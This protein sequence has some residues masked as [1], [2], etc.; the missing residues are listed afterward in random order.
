M[1]GDSQ[2]QK[3]GDVALTDSSWQ[4]GQAGRDLINAQNSQ[5]IKNSYFSMFG[6][7]R[8]PELDWDWAQRVVLEPLKDEIEKRLK[9]SLFGFAAV[10]GVE[11]EAY[12]QEDSSFLA[13][14]ALKT[15]AVD[16]SIESVDSQVPIIQTYAQSGIGKKLLILGT[17]GAGKT[18]T[19][20]KLAEQLVGEAIA[21]PQTMI[22]VIFELSTWDGQDIEQW[23][24]EQLYFKRS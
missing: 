10:D 17:P 1:A 24:I 18:I 5:I 16:G 4:S 7:R 3:Y 2:E 11:V 15:V 9:L 19:L 20:L 21:N 22:P 8:D 12:P 23:L 6:D 13:L 14:E